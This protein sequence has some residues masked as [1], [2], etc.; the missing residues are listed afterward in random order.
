MITLITVYCLLN[1][2]KIHKNLK[3]QVFHLTQSH[4]LPHLLRRIRVIVPNP[5]V[6]TWV[7]ATDPSLLRT[8][9]MLK[10]TNNNHNINIKVGGRPYGTSKSIRCVNN[11]RLFLA[12]PEVAVVFT[13]EEAISNSHI[14]KSI[15]DLKLIG[16]VILSIDRYPQAE[17]METKIT[18]TISLLL[19]WVTM[20]YL[21]CL[22]NKYIHCIFI[23]EI[24]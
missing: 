14:L 12:V 20:N 23:P 10:S 18:N 8:V 6:I 7:L 9:V 22:T 15:A 3:Q 2:L 11:T 1:Q 4:M 24:S 21:L 13:K 16:D 19:G 17:D 5:A